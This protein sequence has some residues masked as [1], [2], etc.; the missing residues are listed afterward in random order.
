MNL[1]APVF[2]IELNALGKQFYRRWLFRGISQQLASGDQLGITG[3]NGSGKSTLMR[4]LAGQMA[5]SEGKVNYLL[6]GSRLPQAEAYR[7]LSW[8]GPYIELYPDLTL[9]EMI[10]VHFRFRDCLL[11]DPGQ[12]P[13]LLDLEGHAHKALRLFSSGMQQ[14]ARVGLALLTQSHMLLLD[15][16][17]SNMDGG[18]AR[19]MLDLIQAYRQERILVI[20]SNLERELEC[21]S[22]QL[23]L[24]I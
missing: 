4:I 2:Q 16:P 11:P 19:R 23:H 21:T 24:G 1:P 9:A 20:A 8:A 13:A 6:A 5:P 10:R 7:H 22:R 12:I 17:T 3:V 18:N 15:E 14:R